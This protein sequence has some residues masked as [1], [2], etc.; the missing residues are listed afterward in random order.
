ML[1]LGATPLAAQPQT[2]QVRFQ[3]PFSFADPQG[4]SSTVVE[5]DS[6]V[7]LAAWSFGVCHDP[8]ELSIAQAIEG[9]DLAAFN[10][11]LGPD[12]HEITVEPDGVRSTVFMAPMVIAVLPPQVDYE[13]LE[14]SYVPTTTAPLNSAEISICSNLGMPPIPIVAT[15]EFG[16]VFP[17][18][19]AQP[20][21][22][23]TTA[24]N[25]L[26]R[27]PETTTTYDLSTGLAQFTI[28][29]RIWEWT[30]NAASTFGF[31]FG[32]RHDA[33]LFTAPFVTPLDPLTGLNNGLGA[34]FF[35]A[36]LSPDNVTIDVLYDFTGM[37]T[38]T[39]DLERPVLEIRYVTIGPSL[40]G[41]GTPIISSIEFDDTLTS[42]GLPLMGEVLI[43]AQGNTVEP[44]Q[45]SGSVLLLPVGEFVRGDCNEDGLL[46]IADPLR[47]LIDLFSGGPGAQCE[48]A[49]DSNDDGSK[50]LSDPIYILEHLFL[51][52]PPPPPPFPSCGEDPTNPVSLPCFGSPTC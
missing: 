5:L 24:P 47:I 52:G 4:D 16:T 32:I 42:Q 35:L 7:S 46:N 23:T 3:I 15:T 25:F 43:D 44:V 13:I 14:I 1:L 37:E 18:V 33:S 29:P 31:R 38:I 40:L 8:A 2:D 12:F 20:V 22:P 11:G 51:G 36:T 30:G 10:G 41:V 17:T 50:D 39:F 19:E 34:E 49:C 45:I 26:F 27:I 28:E 21:I 48:R 6:F 9:A